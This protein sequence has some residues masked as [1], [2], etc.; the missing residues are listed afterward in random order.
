M[1]ITVKTL[2]GLEPL[3]VDELVQLG[4]TDIEPG[5]RVVQ[6]RGD[7]R[8]LYGICLHA[9]TALRVLMPVREFQA[10]DEGGLYQGVQSID[11]SR[12]L[13]ADRTLAVDCTTSSERLDHSYFLALKTKDAIVD[14]I[15]ER[16]GLRPDVDTK[17]PDLRV[18]VYINRDNFVTVSLD[19]SGDPLHHRG[20][21]LATTGA[22]LN[23]VLAAGLIQFS[24]YD[25]EQ[26]FMDPFVGSGT[27]V[28]EAA[29]VATRTAPGLRRAFGFERWAGFNGELWQEMR[30]EAKTH[31]RKAPYPIVGSDISGRAID[32]SRSNLRAAGMANDVTLVKRPVQTVEPPESEAE[33]GI[34]VTNP[35]YDL[36]MEHE[37]IIQL[38]KDIGDALKQRFGGYSAWVFSANIDALKRVGLRASRRFTLMN[39]QL[40]AKLHRFDLYDGSKKR[41]S[42]EEE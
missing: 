19:A 28:T 13:D 2:A 40:D 22:P 35:P 20:Y 9:R 1:Y 38:Y 29:L 8:L 4:A 37:D 25:G 26:P 39:G 17:R 16:T 24:E 18:N 31:V 36:R 34:L 27:I 6:C 3:L 21:R 14:Q 41:R 32:V 42:S 30:E 11:W 33:G 15:R 7:R 10:H 23:E 5:V 12:F